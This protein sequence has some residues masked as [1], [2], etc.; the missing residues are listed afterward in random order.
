MIEDLF[1]RS[2]IHT[3]VFSKLGIWGL[4][5]IP[6]SFIDSLKRCNLFFQPGNKK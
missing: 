2:E 5:I 3:H 1:D 6:V 4:G